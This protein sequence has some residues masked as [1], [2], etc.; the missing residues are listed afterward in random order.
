M[1]VENV[2]TAVL[3]FALSTTVCIPIIAIWGGKKNRARNVAI[4]CFFVAYTN[5]LAILF[6]KFLH[7]TS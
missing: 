2:K 3:V 1:T 7:F 5:I 4:T 6:F